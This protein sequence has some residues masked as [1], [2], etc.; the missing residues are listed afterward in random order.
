MTQYDASQALSD[1]TV[2]TREGLR[3]SGDS[4]S[5]TC[6][7]GISKLCSNCATVVGDSTVQCTRATMGTGSLL[8]RGYSNMV[9]TMN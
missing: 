5:I 6:A 8:C 9:Y 1:P 4:A 3:D 2:K 7:S